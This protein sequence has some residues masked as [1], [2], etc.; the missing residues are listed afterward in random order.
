MKNR[1]IPT[2]LLLVSTGVL[3]TACDLDFASGKTEEKATETTK[4]TSMP[5]LTDIKPLEEGEK[6]INEISFRYYVERILEAHADLYV[7]VQEAK[8]LDRNVEETVYPE[9]WR[10]QYVV[11]DYV[12]DVPATE[13]YLET[14]E[15]LHKYLK[16]S[17]KFAKNLSKDV[18][19]ADKAI[20]QL[21]DDYFAVK[22]AYEAKQKELN[23]ETTMKDKEANKEDDVTNE[24]ENTVAE[25]SKKSESH[26]VSQEDFNTSAEKSDRSSKA[27]ERAA[28]QNEKEEERAARDM[29]RELEK[30]KKDQNRAKEDVQR[31]AEQAKKEADKA[32]AEQREFE[33]ENKIIVLEQK[34]ET[35]Y[36]AEY[37][38]Q[39]E[40]RDEK[41]WKKY[42]DTIIES[43]T[44]IGTMISVF[45]QDGYTTSEL[46]D[47]RDEIVNLNDAL[48]DFLE[49]A[50]NV[51]GYKKMDSEMRAYIKN[52]QSFAGKALKA[53][54]SGNAESLYEGAN[55]YKPI[56]GYNFKALINATRTENPSSLTDDGELYVKG[57]LK[58]VYRE[59]DI[60]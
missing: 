44:L 25:W 19:E 2:L 26:S 14:E 47:I 43:D 18:K 60:L 10:F 46:E 16:S 15:L 35:K 48:Q 30:Q 41:K 33:A 29:Q 34:Q 56:G 58:K 54:T 31:A 22:K 23:L 51:E 32:S 36:K 4:E 21:N 57:L 50:P 40:T 27:K 6:I 42:R 45:G 20:L 39:E 53:V 12:Q 1:K 55:R 59:A 3:L 9:L 5:T 49:N 37:A 24:S 13:I 38:N 11:E 8:Y 28:D 7:G 52:R 17:L